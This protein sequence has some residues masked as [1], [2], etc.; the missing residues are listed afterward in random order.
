[1]RDRREFGILALALIATAG[2]TSAFAQTA[3]W[4][5][6]PIELVVPVSPGGGLDLIARLVAKQLS[7]QTGRTVVV[8]NR[9]GASGTIAG[10]A[11]ARAAP[12]GTTL[13]FQSVSTA[14]AVPLLMKNLPYEPVKGLAAVSLIAR[15]PLVMVTSP[16]LPVNNITEFIELL[17]QNPGKYRYGST[18]MGTSLYLASEL[19]KHRTETD[20]TMVSYKGTADVLPDLMTGRVA[21]LIDGLPPQLDFIKSGRVR[22]MAVTSPGRSELLP[23]VPAMTEV[24]PG[25]EMPF[26]TGIFVPAQTPKPVIDRLSNEL[27]KAMRDPG[28]VQRLK[29]LGS[30]SVGSSAAELDQYWQQQLEYYRGVVQESGL[31]IE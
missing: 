1:M 10:A 4:P 8:V 11:V 13:L 18:G 15:F 2:G 22:A 31:K 9:G 12:D 16:E 30:E 20:I 3:A 26:W 17:K 29:E 14:V 27:S 23:D 6:K 5:S 19:F 21:M 24:I 25:Y 28:L 7:V